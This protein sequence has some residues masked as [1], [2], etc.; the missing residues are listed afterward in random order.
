METDPFAWLNDIHQFPKIYWAN[1][2]GQIFAAAGLNDRL[3][4]RQFGFRCFNK[5]SFEWDGFQDRFIS[6]RF[7][8]QTS[9]KNVQN[10][11]NELFQ[12]SSKCYFYRTLK[13]LPEQ[14]AWTENIY[15]ALRN[16]REK[17]FEKVVLARRVVLDCTSSI[18]PIFLCQA[19]AE[20]HQITFLIQLSPSVAFLG[21]SPEVLY[22]RKK[23]QI[24]CDALAGTRLLSAQEELLQSKKDLNEF[25]IVKDRIID[26]L[27]PLCK[28]API[29][30]PHSLRATST[31]CHLYSQIQGELKDEIT[32]EMILNVLHP[33]PAIGGWPQK[34][35]LAFL[36][37][38]EPFSRGLYSAPVGWKTQDEAEFAVAI[39][40]CL[41]R[42][43]QVYLYAGTG[44]VEGSSPIDEWN[45]SE[46]KLAHLKSFFVSC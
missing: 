3:T 22:H 32:D 38:Y 30:T 11:K 17:K 8:F 20:V 21:S 18:D 35:A 42:D 27:S 29:A 25:Q 26:L 4:S 31:L 41:I 37:D 43:S 15:R 9:S 46:N 28:V 24:E 40:S 33:T 39:R 12:H 44:I 45:E 23:R 34:E 16:I 6:P 14:H 13:S 2:E 10:P 5:P 36:T 7:L 1:R 19:I